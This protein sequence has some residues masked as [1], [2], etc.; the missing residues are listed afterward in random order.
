MT[1]LQLR[2]LFEKFFSKKNHLWM[3]S[4][5]LV[6]HEDPSLLFVNAGMNQFKNMFLG[7]EAPPSPPNTAAIQK[8][9]RAGGKHNDL[10]AIGPS[11][12]HHTFFEMMGNFSFG[13]YFKEEACRLA[14][15]FL[16]QE[17]G[18]PEK[19]MG[20]SVF[21]DDRE[22]AEI[23]HKKIGLPR[24]RIFFLGEEDNFWRM[25][26][27]GPCGPCS[28][29]Y[30]SPEG[31]GAKKKEGLFEI[32]NLVF[33]EY[34]EDQEGRRRPLKKKGIDTGMG[35]ERLLTLLQNKKSNYHTD[36]FSPLMKKASAITSTPY[37]EI[38]PEAEKGETLRSHSA[39]R[40][41]ADHSRA[42]SFLIAD[43]VL[44]SNEGRGYVLRRMI[45]RA[46]YHH[47]LLTD[48]KK[49]LSEMAGCAADHFQ[50]VYPELKEKKSFIQKTLN[51]EEEK[52]SRTL[53]EGR[54]RL[55]KAMG[56]LKGQNKKTLSGEQAFELYD[57]YGFPFDLTQ[58]IT[59][60]QGIQV[61]RSR[62]EEKMNE[63]RE[64]ARQKTR[65]AL[66]FSN[67]KKNYPSLDPLIPKTNFIG[68]KKLE[69]KGRLL[70]LFS[71]KGEELKELK[72]P[73]RGLAVFDQSPF[74]AEGGGQTGDQG[75]ILKK[76]EPIAQITDCQNAA[77]HFFHYFTLEKGSLKKGEFYE[78]QVSKDRRA[79][80]A[81]HH[82]AT[83]LLHSALRAVLGKSVKQ[84]GS[85]AAPDRL[86]FD[87]TFDRPLNPDEYEKIET[88][89]NEQIEKALNV[90]VHIKEH[91]QALDE[92]A[93]SFFEKPQDH[94]RVLKMGDFSMELCGGTHVQN[95]K[96]ILCF[97]LLEQSS[98]GS[99]IRRV[100]AVCGRR[101]LK[102]LRR[103]AGENMEARKFFQIP[104]SESLMKPIE[105]QRAQMKELKKAKPPS[106]SLSLPKAFSSLNLNG[107]KTAYYV[108]TDLEGG[109]SA[110][111]ALADLL[112]KKQAASVLTG[113]FEGGSGP[114]VV[115]FPKAL[116]KK[117]AAGDLI[118]HLGGR[119]GGPPSFAKGVLK[120]AWALNEL[121]ERFLDF[122]KKG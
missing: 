77:E 48:K 37:Q 88:L 86:R 20:V 69:G 116:S 76:D 96:D 75:L 121:E 80:A 70:A 110:L 3:K 122:L 29:I 59:Q 24:D 82:S 39:L 83:H 61:E 17:L 50:R 103:L 26:E 9:L 5:P 44:P 62:F 1:H 13:G 15:D 43:G 78:L 104:L 2:E 113:V 105:R 106:P 66:Q 47:S 8:C 101:A 32:W 12:Y 34:E 71:E 67:Q 4:I 23:W 41:L 100:E 99:G 60:K 56:E 112:K 22:T 81:V 52:F 11:P 102:L 64:K 120:R 98:I 16:T 108:K 93:L 55:E 38:P 25:G 53:D 10:D 33:M 118:S 45:R 87:F 74:Y 97:K 85:L 115:S 79:G 6:P 65:G 30:F 35:L 72:A 51:S 14:W 18:L 19:N 107:E 27:Q 54:G 36:L 89:V 46:L 109:V 117:R 49:G 42:L 68:Y 63:A 28:E 91:Q 111:T 84:A 57:T 95:T 92:G 31:F 90:E 40:V 7:L 58:L 73:M 21:K 94:V 114:I 119:G